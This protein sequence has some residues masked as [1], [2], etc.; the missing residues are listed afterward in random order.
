MDLPGE[1]IE[2]L[3]TTVIWVQGD[4]VVSREGERQ[5]EGLRTVI[6]VI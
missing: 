3:K 2:G 6:L 1:V 4:L 5:E